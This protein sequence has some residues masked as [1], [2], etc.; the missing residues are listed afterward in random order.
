M[1][2]IFIL[3]LAVIAVCSFF[4]IR[5]RKKVNKWFDEAVKFLEERD[6]DNGRTTSSACGQKNQEKQTD[7]LAHAQADDPHARNETSAESN[8]R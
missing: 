1:T 5:M 6:K 7:S 2:L 4:A 3:A 8:Q